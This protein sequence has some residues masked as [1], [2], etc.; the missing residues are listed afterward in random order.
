MT[1]PEAYSPSTGEFPTFTAEMCAVADELRSFARATP[2]AHANR[3]DWAHTRYNIARFTPLL[4]A[5]VGTVFATQQEGNPQLLPF[6]AGLLTG[7][8]MHRINERRA[9]TLIEEGR[10]ALADARET[11][12]QR[13]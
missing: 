11:L 4:P 10:Q 6:A 1:S 12:E 9:Q 5:Y 13:V 7:Y 3:I 8:L 2:L